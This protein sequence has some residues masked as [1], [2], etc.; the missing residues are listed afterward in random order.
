VENGVA[1]GGIESVVEAARAGLLLLFDRV[2]SCVVWC[3]NECV[4][5]DF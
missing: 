4:V 3:D 1:H 2:E 5:D